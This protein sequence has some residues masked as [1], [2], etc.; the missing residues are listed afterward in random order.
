MGISLGFNNGQPFVTSEFDKRN[1]EPELSEYE[2]QALSIIKTGFEKEQLSFDN[3]SLRRYSDNYLTL[4]SPNNNDFCRIK[5]GQK[6]AWISLD[7]WNN[8]EIQNDDRFLEFKK[9][10]QRHWKINL[11]SISEFYKVTDLIISVYKTNCSQ[12]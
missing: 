5:A 10:S 8:K 7:V 6:S 2:K 12:L 9:R 11:P 1:Q 3:V 4:I